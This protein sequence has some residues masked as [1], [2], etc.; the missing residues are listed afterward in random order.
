MFKTAENLLILHLNYDILLLQTQPYLYSELK[1]MQTRQQAIDFCLSLE[2][3]YEDYPFH[4]SNWA[5]MRHVTNNK[6]FAAVYERHEKIWI[7]VKCD[8]NITYMW[9]SA[10]ES[11]IPAYHM[12][13][14]HWNSIIRDGSIPKQEIIK[15]IEDSYELTKPKTK[16]KTKAK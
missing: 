3:V 12:N 7:N 9:R 5:V 1:K 16:T 14:W 10:F 15:M 8:P 4:D 11:V 2:N 6:M 13:K